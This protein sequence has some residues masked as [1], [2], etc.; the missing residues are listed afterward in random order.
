M[1][2]AEAVI[3]CLQDIETYEAAVCVV[4]YINC[5]NSEDCKYDG[6]DSTPCDDCKIKWLQSEAKFS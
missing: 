5:P 4:D 3:Q 2:N 1:T 6:K